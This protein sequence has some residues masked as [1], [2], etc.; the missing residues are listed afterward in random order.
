VRVTG[1][2]VLLEAM[3]AA[4]M[5][6]LIVLWLVGRMEDQPRERTV[7]EESMLRYCWEEA[8]GLPLSCLRALLCN[9][10]ESQKLAQ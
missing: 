8:S 7:Q 3:D 9:M 10:R 4:R 2:L 6:G 1:I 5:H